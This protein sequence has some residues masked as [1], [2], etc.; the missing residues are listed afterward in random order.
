MTPDPHQKAL[1]P[2]CGGTQSKVIRSKGRERTRECLTLQCR[3]RWLTEEVF[4][5]LVR[6][7]A[8]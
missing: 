3:V 5:R 7:R 2:A 8:A 4:R 6:K 1:C